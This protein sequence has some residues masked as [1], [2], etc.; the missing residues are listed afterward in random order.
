MASSIKPAIK[1]VKKVMKKKKKKKPTIKIFDKP[2]KR[3]YH[4]RNVKIDDEETWERKEKA[5]AVKEGHETI[6]QILKD[7]AKS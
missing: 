2:W 5:R 1:K 6:Y 7:F 4:Y 3:T